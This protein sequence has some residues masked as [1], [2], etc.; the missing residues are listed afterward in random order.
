MDKPL[1]HLNV[2]RRLSVD[3]GQVLRSGICVMQHR[4][5]MQYTGGLIPIL[6]LRSTQVTIVRSTGETGN[7]NVNYV[8]LPEVYCSVQPTSHAH[9]PTHPLKDM[10]FNI[11]FISLCL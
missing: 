9:S 2:V 8:L 1:A 4:L 5:L 10:Y 6:S 3:K 7:I 11:F